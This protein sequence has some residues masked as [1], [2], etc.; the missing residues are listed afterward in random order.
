MLKF[1]YFKVAVWEK[2]HLSCLTNIS[3]HTTGGKTVVK[4]HNQKTEKGWGGGQLR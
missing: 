4:Q 3:L 1:T 2:S